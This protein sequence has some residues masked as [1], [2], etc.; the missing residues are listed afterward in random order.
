VVGGFELAEDAIHDA[1]VVAL[2]RWKSDGVPDNPGAWILTA[3][4]RKAIDRLRRETARVDKERAAARIRDLEAFA[5]PQRD[6]SLS[7]IFTCCHPALR[8]EAQVALTLRTLGGL[9]TREIARA[10]VVK[11]ETMAQRLVRAKGKIRTAGIPYRVPPADAMPERMPGVLAV[12]YLV[13]NEGYAATSGDAHIRRDLCR[14][15]IRL[16]RMLTDLMPDEPEAI[17][18]LALMLFHD[19]RH[20]ARTAPDGT[21][22]LLEDQDRALWD[23]N[24]IDEARAWMARAAT[25]R[26]PGPYQIQAAIAQEHVAKPPTNWRHI[27]ALYDSLLVFQRTPVV[28][29][30][31]AV[32]LAM[33]EDEEQ[34]LA[35]IDELAEALDGYFYFHTARA[36]LLTRLGRV[37]EA[38]AALDRALPLAGSEAERAFVR[39]RRAQHP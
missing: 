39:R 19:A 23:S 3:A 37:D 32:A 16:A 30:N 1:L 29:L 8:A 28:R 22:V 38:R 10:F 36:E 6:D 7:L 15:A 12:L 13:F 2:E 14:E 27:R 20:R 25:L 11:E 24:Q 31:R 33:A 5:M 21:P 26:T 18:L 35:E 34:G 9:T 4:R 17:G